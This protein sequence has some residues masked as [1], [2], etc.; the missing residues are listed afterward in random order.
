MRLAIAIAIA[1][2]LTL[3]A[4]TL[5]PS[6][7]SL[8]LPTISPTAA[9]DPL[10][11]LV[12]LIGN[13]GNAPPPSVLWTPN[14]SPECAATNQGELLCCR[15]ALAGDLHVVQWLAALYGYKLNPNDVNGVDCD[16]N[17]AT[18]PGVKMCCQVTA[19]NPL[20]S[21]YCQDY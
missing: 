8:T 2:L 5:I 14:P 6:P 1:P 13:L 3:T 15:G 12:T 17:I 16:T 18:C 4:A 9:S 11:P 7:V 10:D 19:L 21:L 20:L